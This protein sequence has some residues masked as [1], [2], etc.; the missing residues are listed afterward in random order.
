MLVFSLSPP[1]AASNSVTPV[2]RVWEQKSWLPTNHK[3]NKISAQSN[4][5][6]DDIHHISN[7]FHVFQQ[8]EIEKDGEY[9]GFC[10]ES[11]LP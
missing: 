1:D 7:G 2:R 10:A 8:I 6:K 3:K 5:T 11:F 9:I 4:I